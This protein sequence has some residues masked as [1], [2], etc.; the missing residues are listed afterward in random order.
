LGG[1]N[2]QAEINACNGNPKT[3]KLTISYPNTLSKDKTL[4][5]NLQKNTFLIFQ[6]VIN[7]NIGPLITDD[8]NSEIYKPVSQCLKQLEVN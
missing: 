3:C 5:S 1:R 2:L 7:E 8:I 6:T 4:F